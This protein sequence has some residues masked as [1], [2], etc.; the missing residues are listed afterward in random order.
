VRRALERFR[1]RVLRRSSS[2]A[3]NAHGATPEAETLRQRR[4]AAR[5]EQDELRRRRDE[6]AQQVS[7]EHWDLG[8]LAYEMAV[9]D[10]FRLDV[11]VRRAAVL[12]EHDMELAELERKLQASAG[13]STAPPGGSP[14]GPAGGAALAAAGGSAAGAD[15]VAGATTPQ[16]RASPPAPGTGSPKGM[17][18]RV[19]GPLWMWIFLLPGFLGFGVLAGWASGGSGP[20]GGAGSPVRVALGEGPAGSGTAPAASAPGESSTSAPAAE[21]SAAEAS[22]TPATSAVGVGTASRAG[23][24]SRIIEEVSPAGTSGT[25]SAT[26]STGAATKLPPIK[27]VF[28]VMLSNEPYA[29]VF[30]P[31]SKASYLVH[32]LEGKGK[33]LERYY[34]VAHEELANE[35]ALVSGQGPTPQ[36]ATNCPSYA[37]ITPATGGAFG[38]VLGQGCVYPRSTATLGAQ[39]AAK[40]LAWRVY[41]E[42][43]GSGTSGDP[44]GCQH[45]VLGA[46]DP[47]AVPG[48]ATSYATFRDPFL[49]FESV[50]GASRC[51]QD[52][53]ALTRLRA[54][55]SNENRTPALSYIVP[56][57]CHDA[58]P[59]P[60]AAGQQ[61]GPADADGFLKSAVGQILAS[62]AYRKDG[63]LVITTDEAPATGEYADSSSC[64]GQP[65]F[66]NVPAA[67]TPTGL[68][69]GGGEV[70]A[71]LL[72]P[73]VKGGTVESSPYNSF[74]LLRTIEDLFGLT[75][76]GYASLAGVS[77]FAPSLFT[78][79]PS[80]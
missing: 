75:H 18:L 35:V 45:P 25:S 6:L 11:L 23:G 71:L 79:A 31:E 2:G 74:S 21:S 61:A 67:T 4:E 15:S 52:N 47:T 27:H 59:T 22:S 57:L 51:A 66:P 34:A 14:S 5:R 36:T 77:S 43:M 72:S 58:S 3:P 63:L 53:V 42:S 28:V 54:D 17:A 80:G 41:L 20:S 73:Y 49:Y 13:A 48:A 69:R 40:H 24:S 62:A 26:G 10:H 33:L 65:R 30:G 9:R 76:L 56:D 64:C 1:G 32:S 46:N 70:G 78:A 68:P 44:G 37:A 7:K 38:Q 60:C 8:G 50:T 12:Q 39:L 16:G 55:L 29:S 19:S